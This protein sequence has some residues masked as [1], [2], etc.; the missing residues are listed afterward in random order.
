VADYR[1]CTYFQD[2]EGPIVNL[3][4]PSTLRWKHCGAEVSLTQSGDYPFDGRIKFSVRTSK[5]TSFSLRLRMPSWAGDDARVIVNGRASRT[6]A[7]PGTFATVRRRWKN[8]DAVT[9]D[10]PMSTR[11]QAIDAEHP[12]TVALS[13]GPLSLFAVRTG[14]GELSSFTREQLLAAKRSTTRND[15]WLVDAPNGPLRFLPF[16]SIGDEEYSAYLSVK[17]S[18]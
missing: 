7:K 4:I 12:D 18:T 1:L 8:G 9:L 5:S 13:Y 16:T 3:Y 11:L 17:A 6:S 14:S 15:E 2:A 10:I